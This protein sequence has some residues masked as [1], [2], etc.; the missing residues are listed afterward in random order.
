MTVAAKRKTSFEV[1]FDKVDVAKDILGTT[2]L[3]ET[4]DVALAEIAKLRQREKL[5]EMLF[6]PDGPAL[7]DAE[8]MKGAW[9]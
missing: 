6:S 7:D 3:T 5:V 8:V 2:T 1:D 9:R 4:V